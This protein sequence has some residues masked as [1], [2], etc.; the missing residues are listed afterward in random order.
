MNVGAVACRLDTNA[1]RIQ[2]AGMTNQ[3]SRHVAIYLRC[4]TADQA[5]SGLGIEAQRAA[6]E[7]YVA[8]FHPGADVVFYVDAGL[9]GGTLDRPG[10]SQLRAAVRA[11]KVAAVV[12][13][14]MDRASR[15]LSDLLA[16]VAEI[17][18]RGA[19]FISVDE[20]VDTSSPTGKMMLSLLGVFAEF[21][22]E[23][24]ADRTRSA[25][26]AKRARG[27]AFGFSRYGERTVRGRLES[28]AHEV[29]TIDRIRARRADGASLRE[30][31]AELTADG[32]P[33]KRGGAWRACTVDVILKRHG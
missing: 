32:V 16:L 21:E 29:A 33:T 7:A 31:A 6:C 30:I 25:V 28:V 26:A 2:V 19:A 8:A 11:R 18:S 20:R 4:S 22:R 27:E 24:I 9:S 3:A 23:Q 5:A 10:L 17:E 15:S 12:V 1:K 13:K 14:K